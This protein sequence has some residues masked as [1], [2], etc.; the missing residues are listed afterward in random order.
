MVAVGVS[1][2]V[3]RADHEP[4]IPRTVF[5][6]DIGPLRYGAALPAAFQGCKPRR[7]SA[8]TEEYLTFVS[9][10]DESTHAALLVQIDCLGGDR[11]VVRCTPATPRFVKSL[12]LEEESHVYRPQALDPR[13]P[14]PPLM[15]GLKTSRAIGLGDSYKKVVAAY[16]AP[17]LKSSAH[18]GDEFYV[19]YTKGRDSADEESF[20]LR[21]AHGLV[22]AIVISYG[23]G[24][25]RWR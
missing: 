2:R 16:G 19:V 21:F 25:M 4:T 7:G 24:E 3:A 20:Q 6:R 1:V 14:L 22:Y 15:G 13:C 17:S 5:E 9:S 23:E 10:P 12:V 8:P 18:K 11:E